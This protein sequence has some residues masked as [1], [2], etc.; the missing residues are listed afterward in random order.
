MATTNLLVRYRVGDRIERDVPGGTRRLKVEE[1]LY[2]PEAD[3]RFD[4]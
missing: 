2:Q 1:V 4:V 3:K